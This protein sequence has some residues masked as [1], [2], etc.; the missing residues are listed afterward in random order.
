MVDEFIG[1]IVVITM[2]VDLTGSIERMKIEA[3][4]KNF[5]ISGKGAYMKSLITKGQDLIDSVTWNI[6]LNEHPE[7]TYAI[8]NNDRE[9]QQNGVWNLGPGR[10]NHIAIYLFAK[11]TH[12]LWNFFP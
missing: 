4:L 3:S 5:P 12:N 11:P 2:L 6:L 8:W 9:N 1:I 7:S 10:C